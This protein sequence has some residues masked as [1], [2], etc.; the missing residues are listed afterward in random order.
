MAS[1]PVHHPETAQMYY[2]KALG[3]TLFARATHSPQVFAVRLTLVQGQST[4]HGSAHLEIKGRRTS[5]LSHQFR[6]HFSTN[7]KISRAFPKLRT[8]RL[9]GFMLSIHDAKPLSALFPMVTNLL[10]CQVEKVSE[11]LG[12]PSNDLEQISTSS[13][14]IELTSC[15]F[16]WPH[17]SQVTFLHSTGFDNKR[18]SHALAERASAGIQLRRLQL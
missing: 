12:T 5:H 9:D 3:C 11:L 10:L 2:P 6:T 15:R 4:R 16:L 18:F 14:S 7:P 17:L 13:G 8:L 1:Q